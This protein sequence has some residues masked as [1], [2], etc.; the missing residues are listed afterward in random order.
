[1]ENLKNISKDEFR[2]AIIWGDEID[3]CFKR[4]SFQKIK[5]NLWKEINNAVKKKGN[6]IVCKVSQGELN[7]MKWYLKKGK[8]IN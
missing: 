1:M 2:T 6:T 3:K 7:V 5:A 4:S 8:I